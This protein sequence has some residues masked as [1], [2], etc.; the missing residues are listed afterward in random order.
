[1]V[2]EHMIIVHHQKGIFYMNPKL[3]GVLLLP[4]ICHKISVGGTNSGKHP[5]GIS[6]LLQTDV[7]PWSL[8]L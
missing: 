1:M 3:Q 2:T 7:L 4:G 6:H 5:L 8:M